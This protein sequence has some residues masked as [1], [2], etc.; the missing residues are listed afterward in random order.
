[1]LTEGG[2]STRVLKLIKLIVPF[3]VGECSVQRG[4]RSGLMLSFMHEGTSEQP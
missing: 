3:S 4:A 1:M 2:P